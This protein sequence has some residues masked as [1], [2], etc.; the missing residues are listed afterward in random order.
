MQ[1]NTANMGQARA[2]ALG[3]D[4]AGRNGWERRPQEARPR[5]AVHVS[6]VKG[7]DTD[8]ELTRFSNSYFQWGKFR[9]DFPG[10]QFTAE[11]RPLLKAPL[12]V[13]N[14]TQGGTATTGRA[15]VQP[16]ESACDE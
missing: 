10:H 8:Y 6:L 9:A 5:C 14:L 13:P 1:E 15:T 2:K 16:P 3:Q 4:N 7:A 12:E 11:L